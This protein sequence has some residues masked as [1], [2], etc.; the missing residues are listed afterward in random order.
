MELK[1]LASMAKAREAYEQ[2]HEFITTNDLSPLG[3]EIF[4]DIGK[5]YEND[6][7]AEHVDLEIL[8]GRVT[9]RLRAAHLKDKIETI[10]ADL[11]EADVSPVNIAAELL[12][13]KRAQIGQ[14]LANS[15]LTDDRNVRDILEQ[16]QNILEAQELGVTSSEEFTGANLSSIMQDHFSEEGVIKISPR[17]LRDRLGGGL[18]RGHHLIVVALPET[19][20]TL[21]SIHLAVGVAN[22]GRRVLYV[23]NEEPMRDIL[24]RTVSCMTGKTTKEIQEDPDSAEQRARELGYSNMTFVGLDPGSLWEVRA[25]VAKYRPD[26]LIVDQIRHIQAKSE[27]RTTQLE[28]VA[29]GIRNIARRYNLSA[30]SLTQG[31]D[32]ARDKLVLDM[33]DVDSSNVGI[34]GACD[35]LLMLGSNEEYR[36]INARML[37]LAKNKISGNHD[38]WPISIAPEISRIIDQ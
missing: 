28:A 33:G 15:I 23:G 10:F 12:D 16:Y 24:V 6:D 34:P 22:A 8:Q 32:S 21:F 31:A 18:R 25:L 38:S 35:G 2:V 29:Q 5:F 20:K 17:S 3:A 7:T 11:I 27:N 13:Q 9:R 4:K 30:I 36:R 1:I 14:D 26:V 37:T 19:G